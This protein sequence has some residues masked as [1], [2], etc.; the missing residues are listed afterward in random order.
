MS[1]LF[2]IS[3]AFLSVM[4][5]GMKFLNFLYAKRSALAPYSA[6]T[7]SELEL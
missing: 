1:I 3:L 7:L 6:F 2:F 5:V 4:F